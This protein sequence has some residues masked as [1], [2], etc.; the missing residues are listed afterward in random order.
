MASNSKNK[1]GENGIIDSYNIILKRLWS[2]FFVFR[3]SRIDLLKKLKNVMDCVFLFPL[4][5]SGATS[6][7]KKGLILLFLFIGFGVFAQDQ[8]QWSVDFNSEKSEIEITAKMA[9]GWHLYSQTISNDVGP[10]PTEFRFENNQD[11]KF[12]GK[13]GE[14]K[15]IVEFDP[16]FEANLSYFK[17]EALF[18]QEIELLN[19][20]STSVTVSYMVCNE[21]MCM[22]PTDQVIKIELK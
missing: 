1:R 2:L 12:I 14:P 22:P 21:E 8:V 10:I 11:I 5:I 13:V 9:E 6:H 3:S 4:C 7:M 20:T 16:N 19:P 17:S 18:T 15:P